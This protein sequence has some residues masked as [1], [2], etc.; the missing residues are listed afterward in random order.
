MHGVIGT[1]AVVVKQIHSQVL[2]QMAGEISKN[3]A[4]RKDAKTVIAIIC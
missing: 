3:V 4:A 2:M 1:R